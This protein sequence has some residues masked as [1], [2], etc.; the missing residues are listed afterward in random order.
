MQFG[1]IATPRS[2]AQ[3]T[4]LAQQAERDGYRTLLL[5]DT[6]HIAS[7]F[8]TLAAAA[9]VTATLRLRPHVLA[10]PLRTATAT[11]REVA[12]LQLLSAGRFELGIGIGR[13]DAAGEAEKLGRPWG[14][15]AE[16]RAHL[17]AT[18]AAVRAG[19]DP[20]PPVVIAAS[21]PRMLAAAATVADRIILA[22]GPL[23]TESELAEM[24]RVVRDNTDRDI[25]FGHQLVGLGDQVPTWIARQ[26][27]HTADELRAAGAAGFL[28][29]DPGSAAAALAARRDALGI[30]EVLVPED[31][32]AAFAPV[33]AL[34]D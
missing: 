18:V 8:P 29:P 22:A 10:A 5:P 12:A 6:L 7:P 24:V 14:S 33:R 25:R 9:G 3:W 1:L 27:G 13:P 30:D 19:V 16:R 32:A 17:L 11:V 26:F 23:T 31:L 20:A 21:G 34:L 2:G 4:D 28:D 15:A